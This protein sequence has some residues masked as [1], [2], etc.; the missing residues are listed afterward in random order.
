MRAAGAWCGPLRRRPLLQALAG[1]GL[2]GLAAGPGAQAQP[3]VDRPPEPQAARPVRVP[4]LVVHRL[5]NGVGVVVVPQHDLPLV[6][7]QLM[8]RAGR[9]LD[10][11]G[12]AG[13]VGLLTTLLTRGVRRAGRLVSATDQAREA[14]A[15]GG[16]LISASGWRSLSLGMTVATPRWPAA[17]ALLTEALRR[18]VLAAD[19]LDRARAQA[20]DNLR[21]SLGQPG[22]L[23]AMALRRSF[24][25]ATPYG[26]VATLDSLQRVA[27]ADVQQFHARQVRPE[28]TVLVLAGDVSA[29]RGAQLAQQLL[30]DWE[31]SGALLPQA[32]ADAP[33]PQAASLLLVDLPDS[34]QSSVAVAAP[35]AAIGAADRRVGQ[36]ANAVLG[37]GYSARLNTAVRIRRGLSYGAYSDVE[38]TPGG[39]MLVASTQTAH[40]TAAEALAVVR[41]ELLR[42]AEVPPTPDELAARQAALVGGFARG[43]QTTQGLAALVATQLANG[44]PLAELQRFVPEVLAVT[45]EQVQA[46]ARQHWQPERLRAVVV[47]DL[48]A[49]G[50]A[51]QAP[52]PAGSRR[53]AADQL[54]LDRLD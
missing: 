42:L 46:F 25:G 50:P 48:A 41:A 10:P 12:R 52:G 39:G 47:G 54:D 16:P 4:P 13:T 49:A 21:L 43:L 35:C 14:E 36:V 31:P 17:L 7:A 33:Q 53:V 24:W 51:F 44:R 20:L 30:G 28:Q 34:G 19:E 1:G 15:L 38:A 22:E 23:A 9:E 40:A 29:E 8:V 5:G 32:P 27:W 37:G 26:A 6:S 11:P 3:G 18:P 45:P 2:L